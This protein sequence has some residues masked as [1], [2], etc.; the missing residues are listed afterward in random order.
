MHFWFITNVYASKMYGI[1]I[2]TRMRA[3]I[4]NTRL[5]VELCNTST[6]QPLVDHLCLYFHPFVPCFPSL[7][8]SITLCLLFLSVRLCF[9]F[10]SFMVVIVSQCIRS[11]LL[12]QTCIYIRQSV[13]QRNIW[14][15]ETSTCTSMNVFKFPPAELTREKSCRSLSLGT[16]GRR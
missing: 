8:N 11:K 13:E 14:I 4:N 15:R 12:I 1:I 6:V 2:N 3:N 9:V 7:L 10:D 16:A 5:E